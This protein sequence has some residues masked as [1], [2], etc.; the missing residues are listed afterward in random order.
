MKPIELTNAERQYFTELETKTR[1]ARRALNDVFDMY[2][3]TV[4]EVEKKAYDKQIEIIE[5]YKLN[6]N[7]D[8][9]VDKETGV[10]SEYTPAEQRRDGTWVKNPKPRKNN[11][12]FD[13]IQKFLR[14]NRK[15]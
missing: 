11:L 7:I 9:K 8:Y 14:E 6:K 5:K 2:V 1:N 3:E 4:E 10:M 13:E 15:K 12:D